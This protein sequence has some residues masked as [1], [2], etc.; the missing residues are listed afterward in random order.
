[1][2]LTRDHIWNRLDDPI[3][4]CVEG[5]WILTLKVIENNYYIHYGNVERFSTNDPDTA[6]RKFTQFTEEDKKAQAELDA[7]SCSAIGGIVY[8]E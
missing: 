1:M 3:Y 5:P 6:A 7:A 2:I 4:L 8:E